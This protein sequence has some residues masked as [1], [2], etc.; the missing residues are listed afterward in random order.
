MNRN[1]ESIKSSIISCYENIP[2]RTHNPNIVEYA[3]KTIIPTGPYRGLKFSHKR[4]PYLT[5]VMDCLSPDSPYRE[6]AIMFPAQSGKTFTA[7]TTAMYYIEA[8][9]SEIIYATSDQTAAVKWLEREIEPRALQSGIEFK[10]EVDTTSSR[11]TGNTSYSKTFP[12]GNIDIAS[13]LSPAQLASSTKRVIFGDEVDRW[14]IKLG[15]QGSVINQLRARG[16]A[17]KDLAKILWFSTP[18]TEDASVILQLYLQGDQRLYYVPCPF[19]GSFQLLD[20]FEGRGYGLKYEYKNGRIYKKSI[21]LICENKNCGRGIKEYSKPKMLR[22]G[23]WKKS[24]IAEY[25]YFASF[26]LNGLYSFQLSW[27]DMVVSHD[28]SKKGPIKKQDHD[29]LKMG[30]A[31]KETGTR[32][33]ATKII[34]NRGT[35]KPGKVPDGVLYLVAGLDVQE[36]SETNELNPARI[37]MEVL[38]IG[39][40]YRTWSIEYN[41]FKG[42]VDDPYSGA[43]EKLNEYAIENELTYFRNDGFGFPISLIFIDSGSGKT[44]DIVYRFCNRWQ[45]TFPIK[46]QS[47]IKTKKNEKG[48]EVI[49]GNTRRF[50]A[51]NLDEDI[52]LYLINTNYYKNQ[53]YHNLKIGRQDIEPQRPGFCDFP[54]DYDEKYF[55][56]LTA[57]ERRRDGSFHNPT[58]RRNEPLDCRVYGLCA[59]DVYLESEVLNYRAWAKKNGASPDQL[60]RITKKTVL[61]EM[62]RQTVRRK[63][64]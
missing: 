50:R 24:A 8:V 21:E 32:P 58:G 22:N 13:A 7:N 1:Y 48:D 4:A 38:G 30:R 10:V 6:V 52:T 51:S 55:N 19:C 45:N 61:E 27:F 59:G 46:G 63:I 26:H 41:V 57:E 39:A 12:G 18:T 64:V 49:Q 35:Y 40:G 23:Q 37:E 5:E 47:T 25:D 33:K 17:W 44:S 15:E 31:H 34:E 29:T 16:Q 14:K 56:G 62:Q 20:F 54:A 9:P 43:W 60:L 3:E 53:I 11:R 36:G 2:T 28:E 42:D